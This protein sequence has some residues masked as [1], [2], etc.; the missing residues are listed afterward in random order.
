MALPT[1]RDE[2]NQ[3]INEQIQAAFPDIVK[4]QEFF[5]G[6]HEFTAQFIA[7]QKELAT[8]KSQLEGAL[9]QLERAS[10]TL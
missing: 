5:P 7:V 6:H 9:P 2:L 8:V 1:S 3:V 10:L 4:L